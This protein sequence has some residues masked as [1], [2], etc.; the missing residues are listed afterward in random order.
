[1]CVLVGHKG[2]DGN[3]RWQSKLRQYNLWWRGSIRVAGMGGML[4]VKRPRFERR[5][6]VGEGI[7]SLRALS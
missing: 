7:A 2:L 1:M 6:S 3:G 4:C 5:I